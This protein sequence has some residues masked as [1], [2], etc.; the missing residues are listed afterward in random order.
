MQ[1]KKLL[2]ERAVNAKIVFR[3][4]IV[5]IR[6]LNDH[7]V[8]ITLPESI[9]YKELVSFLESFGAIRRKFTPN[10]VEQEEKLKIEKNED[11][12]ENTHKQNKNTEDK[13]SIDKEEKE[14]TKESDEQS[15]SRKRRR[16][17]T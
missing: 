14:Q 8:E 7:E 10:F 12:K 1:K 13:E 2:V 9:N 16:K 17:T 11:E 5:E 4:T 15:S 3:G 6:K